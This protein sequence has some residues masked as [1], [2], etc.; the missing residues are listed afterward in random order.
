M[1]TGFYLGEHTN[2]FSLHLNIINYDNKHKL[3]F[4]TEVGKIK[5]FLITM[6]FTKHKGGCEGGGS[7]PVCTHNGASLL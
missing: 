2:S 3:L 6:V 1:K 7:R 4:I 5:T